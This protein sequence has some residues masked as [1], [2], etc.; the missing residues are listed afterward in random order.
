MTR[1]QRSIKNAVE[2][3]GVA[4]HSGDA[5]HV[6]LAPAPVGSGIIFKRTDIDD[7][8]E[9]PANS[10]YLV[11]SQ[12]RTTLRRG[13]SEV[14]MV[15]HLLSAAKGIEVDN[16]LVELDGPE[17]PGLD[18][19]TSS[20]IDHIRRG[21]IFEQKQLRSCLVL[22]EPV[23]VR[24][25]DME[26]VALPPTGDGLRIRYIPEYPQGI[27]SSNVCIELSPEVYER[28]IAP[29]RTFVRAEEVET[30]LAA[31]YGKGANAENTVVLGGSED[32]KM[33]LE[34]EPTRHK[35]ADLIGDLALLGADLSAD[36][37]ATRSGHALNQELARELRACFNAQEIAA[38]EPREEGY[39]IRDIVRILPHRYPFLLVDRVISV[40]GTRR[41]VGLKNV[42]INEEFFQGHWPDHPVMP[43]VLQLESMAQVA[44]I[45]LLRKLE[46]TG[47]IAVLASIDK[48][49]FRGSVVPGDQLLIEVE[50]LRLNRN[51]GQVVGTTKVGR[52]L[53]AEATLSF[54]LIDA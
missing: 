5:V 42:T 7:P 54:A 29:A 49:R 35:I 40:E 34:Q 22:D 15:E 32:P 46:H 50:T 44:G 18:G 47:K 2:F 33:R 20:Y 23:F 8:A 16:L 27:D 10:D 26:I 28:E 4:L 25:G 3:D 24:D 9:V 13:G 43:G 53:A 52:R 11:S 31:G 41:A 6:R 39:D 12:R 51:R 21:N 38:E 17:L 36:I 45:L 19:S 48:V 14:S 30:L 1:N 37:I